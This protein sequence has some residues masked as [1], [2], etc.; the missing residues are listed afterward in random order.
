MEYILEMR[1][2][3]RSGAHIRK[4]WI[5]NPLQ[6]WKYLRRQEPSS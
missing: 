1:R 4:R 5:W 6:L 3:G 2:L